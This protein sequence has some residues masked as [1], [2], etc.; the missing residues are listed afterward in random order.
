[1][2]GEVVRGKVVIM[3]IAGVSDE[4][5]TDVATETV[6]VQAFIYILRF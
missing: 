4:R 5:I 1:M 3:L 6:A 2:T